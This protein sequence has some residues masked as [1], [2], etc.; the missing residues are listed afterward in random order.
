MNFR[1]MGMI[2]KATSPDEIPGYDKAY[3]WSKTPQERLDAALRL[4]RHA[5]TIYKANPANPPLTHGDRI[6]KLRSPAERRKR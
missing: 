5:K 3:W 6:L 4:I 1:L 2:R